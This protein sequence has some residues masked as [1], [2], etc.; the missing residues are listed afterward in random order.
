MK[1][2][3]VIDD[4]KSINAKYYFVTCYSYYQ[5]TRTDRYDALYAIYLGSCAQSWCSSGASHGTA[6]SSCPLFFGVDNEIS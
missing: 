2:R 3:D 6:G 1:R 5:E 4:V